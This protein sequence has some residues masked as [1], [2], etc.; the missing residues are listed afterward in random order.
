M[1]LLKE[2]N[3][4]LHNVVFS[5]QASLDRLQPLPA[6]IPLPSAL[7]SIILGQDTGRQ[8]LN[9]VTPTHRHLEKCLCFWCSGI[10][11]PHCFR[12]LEPL[13]YQVLTPANTNH[14]KA[15]KFQQWRWEWMAWL[16]GNCWSQSNYLQYIIQYYFGTF[17]HFVTGNHVIKSLQVK[18][19]ECTPRKKLFSKLK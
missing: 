1:E 11:D 19:F 14:C 15:D 18:Q 5:N 4:E 16:R 3:M 12:N 13:Q 9:T 2:I 6:F 7:P 17:G 10:S 8:Q